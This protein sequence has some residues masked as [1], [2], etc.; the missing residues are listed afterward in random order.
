MKNLTRQIAFALA[1][2][3]LFA[4]YSVSANPPISVSETKCEPQTDGMT[5]CSL[6]WDMSST[7]RRYFRI[8]S[9]SLNELDWV[10]T[11]H[12]ASIN[13]IGQ[14]IVESGALYRV[15]ACNDRQFQKGC[16]TSTAT[17]ATDLRPVDELP[18]QME[19]VDFDGMVAVYT[20]DRGTSRY[21]QLTQFNVYLLTDLV[22]R[23]ALK[24][25]D[26]LSAMH[27]PTEPAG[28]P[29]ID[30]QVLH[31]IHEVYEGTRTRTRSNPE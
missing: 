11:R 14:D 18:T 31:N 7:P 12:A 1:T 15:I 25:P 13:P 3:A 2:F 22:N 19:I 20:V 5:R 9:L 28:R 24:D 16:V 10:N 21:T 17:W 26:L 27:S 29:S 23:V 4:S 30:H 6:H 8:Q